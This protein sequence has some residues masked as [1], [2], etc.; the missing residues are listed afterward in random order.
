MI[1]IFYKAL[2][3]YGYRGSNLERDQCALRC[4]IMNWRY[5]A[6][7][8]CLGLEN[9]RGCVQ[10]CMSGR[11]RRN[12]E[13]GRWEKLL[14]AQDTYVIIGLIQLNSILHFFLL[15]TVHKAYYSEIS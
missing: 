5:R 3:F 2:Y 8:E 12:A 15:D 13:K 6:V 1:L 9:S 10:G 7:V 14:P 11:T 4:S